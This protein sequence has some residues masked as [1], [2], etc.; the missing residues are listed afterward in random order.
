M[1]KKSKGDTGKPDGSGRSGLRPSFWGF[2]HNEIRPA[3]RNRAS[4]LQA[5]MEIDTINVEK[6]HILQQWAVS[7]VGMKRRD[8]AYRTIQEALRYCLAGGPVTAPLRCH[9]GGGQG[10][11]AP[12]G[13]RSPS[14]M[15]CK[16]PGNMG[17]EREWT[18]TLPPPP[19]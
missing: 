19:R 10:L 12:G 18:A 9:G 7:L 16:V 14:R 2:E 4:P 8:E 15:H 3:S 13:M 17:G 5:Y 11:R 1:R 6:T